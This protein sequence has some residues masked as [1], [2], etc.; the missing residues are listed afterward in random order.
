MKLCVLL[1]SAENKKFTKNLEIYTNHSL[2]N[3]EL[4]LPPASYRLEGRSWLSYVPP[5]NTLFKNAALSPSPLFL[6]VPPSTFFTF[7]AL[8][9]RVPSFCALDLRG[10]L[11]PTSSSSFSKQNIELELV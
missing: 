4:E 6:R 5:P 11:E 3:F 8:F 9:R 7:S 2:M 1:R 10:V